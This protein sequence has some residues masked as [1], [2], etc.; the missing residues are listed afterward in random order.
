MPLARGGERIAVELN[1]HTKEG[2]TCACSS[3]YF[4]FY[5]LARRTQC[6]ATTAC[7]RSTYRLPGLPPDRPQELPREFQQEHPQE[8][9]QESPQ[10]FQ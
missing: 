8:S 1:R 6:V 7:S 3:V 9:K 10:E 4:C 5:R 2:E